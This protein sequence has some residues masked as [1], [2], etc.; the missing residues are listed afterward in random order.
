[1]PS[2]HPQR[3]HN[4]YLTDFAEPNIV[5]MD[6]RVNASCLLRPSNYPRRNPLLAAHI[7]TMVTDVVGP[8]RPHLSVRGGSR[9][10]QVHEF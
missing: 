8:L 10:V 9:M 7:L 5:S 1:M 3:A 2:W 6:G 4:S